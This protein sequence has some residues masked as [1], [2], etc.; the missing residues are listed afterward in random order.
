MEEEPWDELEPGILPPGGARSSGEENE[1]RSNQPKLGEPAPHNPSAE[2]IFQAANYDAGSIDPIE[3]YEE[4]YYD[5]SVEVE[6]E[7]SSHQDIRQE[8]LKIL[9]MADSPTRT[10]S[11]TYGVHRTSTGGLVAGVQSETTTKRLPAALSGSLFSISRNKHTTSYRDNPSDNTPIER[12]IEDLEFGEKGY[13]DTGSKTHQS[14][15]SW[16]SRYSVDGTFASTVGS[17]SRKHFSDATDRINAERTSATGLTASSAYDRSAA[18][19]DFNANGFGSGFSFRQSHVWGKQGVSVGANTNLYDTSD[20]LPD[21]PTRKSWQEQ[22]R[23][24]KRQRRNIALAAVGILVF[25]I[26]ISTAIARKKQAMALDNHLNIFVTSDVPFATVEQKKFI[27]DLDMIRNQAD[28][29]FHLG[30]IQNV[31]LTGCDLPPYVELSAMLQES[32]IPSFIVPGENDWA[33]CPDPQAAFERWSNTFVNFPHRAGRIEIDYQQ[34]RMENFAF[35]DKGVLFIGLHVIGG[36]PTSYDEFGSRMN[37][38]LAW[39]KAMYNVYSEDISGIVIFG[40]AAPGLLQLKEFFD[41]MS[42]FLGPTGKPTLY[43]HSNSG[44]G[45]VNIYRPFT[46]SN[47][48][49]VQAPMGGKQPPL[50]ITIGSGK[51]VF[52]IGGLDVPSQVRL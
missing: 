46:Y 37:D 16:S 26:T 43:V 29:L 14:S 49:A 22:V 5:D 4:G 38:N 6:S 48:V 12:T 10:T 2:N 40:N 7:L 19:K 42:S 51:H 15:R 45:V 1:S 30:N 44:T 35:Q 36:R 25:I 41:S 52:S 31:S 11:S 47:L 28:F 9:E 24:R 20:Q 33:N 34:N 32:K 23:L 17:P 50:K 21:Q 18:G 39:M 8:A 27:R 3:S 13:V